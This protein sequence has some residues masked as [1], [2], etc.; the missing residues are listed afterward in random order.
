[1]CSEKKRSLSCHQCPLIVICESNYHCWGILPFVSLHGSW[2]PPPSVCPKSILAVSGHHTWR[3]VPRPLATY[4]TSPLVATEELTDD[5]DH[6]GPAEGT[7]KLPGLNH[8]THKHRCPFPHHCSW[9]RQ[10]DL[11]LPALLL[12]RT[13]AG[14]SNPA[15]SKGLG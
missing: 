8:A 3:E 1:M 15:A 5:T 12:L 6:S 7:G 10:Q 13:R 14:E 9:A 11:S 4:R 2:S